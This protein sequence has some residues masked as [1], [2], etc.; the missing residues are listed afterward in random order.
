ML[1]FKK[2]KSCYYILCVPDSDGEMV[3]KIYLPGIDKIEWTNNILQIDEAKI[4]YKTWQQAE[5]EY[6]NIKQKW[7]AYNNY[8]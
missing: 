6:I 3:K 7:I 8:K 2:K 5:Q 1:G 4:I